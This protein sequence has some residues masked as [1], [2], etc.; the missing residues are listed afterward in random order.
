MKYQWKLLKLIRI[1]LITLVKVLFPNK[2][3]TLLSEVMQT[4]IAKSNSI[5]DAEPFLCI[6]QK[7]ENQFLLKIKIRCEKI[8]N[9]SFD[10]FDHWNVGGIVSTPWATSTHHFICKNIFHRHS[11]WHARFSRQCKNAGIKGDVRKKAGRNK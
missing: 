3:M 8:A 7:L 11:H 5:H 4:C 9:R 10:A 1:W 6:I 2:M